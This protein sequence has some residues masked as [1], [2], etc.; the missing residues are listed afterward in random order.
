MRALRSRP[1][2]AFLRCLEMTFLTSYLYRCH[3]G[4]VIRYD[5][6]SKLGWSVDA[7]THGIHVIVDRLLAEDWDNEDSG[8]NMTIPGFYE[9]EDCVVSIVCRRVNA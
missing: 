7:R 1:G 3:I 4:K 6:V 2:S 5:T 9:E 8:I